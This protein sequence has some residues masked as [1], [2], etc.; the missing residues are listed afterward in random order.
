MSSGSEILIICTVNGLLFGAVVFFVRYWFM[1][2]D[3]KI[4]QIPFLIP[5]D[6]CSD[7]RARVHQ[8]LDEIEAE[9]VTVANRVTR[10]EARQ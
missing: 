5:R 9:V 10:L 8:R 6:E 4:D 2:V 7:K 1:R 3:T